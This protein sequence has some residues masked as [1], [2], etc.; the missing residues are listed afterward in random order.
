MKYAIRAKYL[1]NLTL[2]VTENGKIVHRHYGPSQLNLL[3]VEAADV[4][5]QPGLVYY[6]PKVGSFTDFNQQKIWYKHLIG[7][8]VTTLLTTFKVRRPKEFKTKLQQ[9]RHRMINCPVDFVIGALTDVN[10]LT[11]ELY[12][13]CAKEKLPFI[14]VSF[15]NDTDLYNKPW[16][17]IRDAV[18]DYQ[19]VIFI[20]HD[21]VQPL[22]SR[23][24]RKIQR[25][26]LSFAQGLNL[27]VFSPPHKCKAIHPS[28]LKALGLY[29]FK[30]ALSS[31][32]DCDYY[33]ESFDGRGNLHYDGEEEMDIVTLRGRVLKAANQY[34]YHPGYGQELT[35]R[36]PK[37]LT[38]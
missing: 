29:P 3:R 2:F 19:P 5:L 17:W 8:G 9:A 28:V 7:Q 10:R 34:F 22:S 1:D 25:K 27:N 6:E 37:R 24:L 38:V 18:N 26:W 32:S 16:Q 35:V 13:L 31:G 23:K 20:E 11:P 30:G 12:R 36:K 33:I 15:S 14:V 21:Q 4:D